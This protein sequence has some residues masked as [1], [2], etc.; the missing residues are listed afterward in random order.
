MELLI[1]CI[2]RLFNREALCPQALLVQF[3]KVLALVFSLLSDAL[4]SLQFCI[5]AAAANLLSRLTDSRSIL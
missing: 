2:V 4:I 1:N 3:N 5:G